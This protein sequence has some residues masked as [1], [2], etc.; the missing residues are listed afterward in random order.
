MGYQMMKPD[1]VDFEALLRGHTVGSQSKLLSI[2]QDTLTESEE[3][4]YAAS[5]YVH[6]N[7]DSKTDFPIN[8]ESVFRMIGFAHKKNAK[9]TL[10]NNF[11]I[12]EDYKIFLQA[13][14][15]SGEAGSSTEKKGGAGLNKEDI[16]LNAQR[17]YF[18]K[19]MYDGQD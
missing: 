8:L 13:A 6:V 18:Q 3:Q 1:R 14:A 9:R 15:P 16:K 19:L 5:L 11:T 4:W 2:L 12:N 7:Y 10:E 17:R